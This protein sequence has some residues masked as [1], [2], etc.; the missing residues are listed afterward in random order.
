MKL[1]FAGPGIAVVE[2]AY[3]E[4]ELK[5]IWKELTTL[6]NNKQL[7]PAIKTGPSRDFIGRPQKENWGLFLEEYYPNRIYSDILR[8]NRKVFSL[9]NYEFEQSNLFFRYIL[10]CNSDVTLISYYENGG[11][12]KPHRDSSVYTVLSYFYKEPKQF[13]GGNLKLIDFDIEIE[14]KNNMMIYL[15]SVYTHEVTD[16][17]MESTSN[18]SGRYCMSQFLFVENHGND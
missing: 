11:F 6:T 12:Y 4:F 1:S 3:D 13:T 18:C 7:Q 14:I 5:D 17:S 2:D 9:V 10:N 15:P 16:V 8:I